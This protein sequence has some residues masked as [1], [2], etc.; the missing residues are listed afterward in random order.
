MRR[1]QLHPR[2]ALG[3][4]IK[5]RNRRIL[6]K[7]RALNWHL[8]IPAHNNSK[9]FLEIFLMMFKRK[10]RINKKK[11]VVPLCLVQTQRNHCLVIPGIRQ[12]ESRFLKI[13]C[14]VC[15]S[16]VYFHNMCLTTSHF[17]L[18]FCFL[19]FLS[20]LF[21]SKEPTGPLKQNLHIGAKLCGRRGILRVCVVY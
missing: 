17:L 7:S 16:Y 15:L 8:C 11:T 6:Q 9:I 1:R 19:F 3:F 4:L 5:R 21:C 2:G 14:V 12:V 10:T 18:A 13:W 20:F